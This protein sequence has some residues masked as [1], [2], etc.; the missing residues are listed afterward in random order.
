MAKLIALIDGS[1]YSQS[2]CDHT[3]WIAGRTGSAV[4]LLHVLGRRETAS[5]PADLSGNITLG[6]R[7]TLLEELSSLDEQRAKLSQRR[8]RAILDDAKTRLETDGVGPV[9]TRLRIGDI[10]ETVAEC[11]ADADMVVIGKRGEAADFAKLHLGSNLERIARSSRK[12][13]FVASRAFKPIER[14]LVAYDGGTSSMKA[15]DHVAR[16][17]LFSGLD[18]RL[19]TVGADTGENRR[20]LNDARAVLEAGGHKVDAGIVQGQPE[21]AIAQAVEAEGIDLLVMGAYGHSRIR[22]FIIGSTTAEMLRSCKIPVV[23]FR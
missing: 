17:F 22:S 23:L 12:P 13:V 14:F 21:T 1:V 2:V 10:V 4:E 3:A 11:E 20:R 16:S 5:V 9:T 15:I 18:C 6:A 7:S 8:G 19:I